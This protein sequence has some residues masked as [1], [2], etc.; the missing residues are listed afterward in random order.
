MIRQS[1]RD[2][3]AVT[4]LPPRGEAPTATKAK[5]S[6]WTDA[7]FAGMSLGVDQWR[8][9]AELQNVRIVG[10]L[11]IGHPGSLRSATSFAATIRARLIHAHAPASL[12]EAVSEAIWQAWKSWAD[13]VTIPS[14]PWYPAFFAWP[15]PV[16]PPMP[17]SPSPLMLCASSGINGMLPLPLSAAITARLAGTPIPGGEAAIGTLATQVSGAFMQWLASANVMM[18]LGSGTT[19]AAFPFMPIAPVTGAVVH[20][21]GCLAAA[22]SFP[23]GPPALV[24]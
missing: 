11:A 5:W 3:I 2:R 1:L 6:M 23:A 22:P 12:A 21:R 13:N 20:S 14:L 19:A 18:A 16:A 4:A 7:T 9:D 24:P 10:G 17:N 15:G 8:L